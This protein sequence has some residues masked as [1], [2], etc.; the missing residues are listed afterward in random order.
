MC[1]MVYPDLTVALVSFSALLQFLSDKAMAIIE[2]FVLVY[3]HTSNL[4]HM[5]SAGQHLYC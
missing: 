2:L 4:T 5:N 3:E 1:G